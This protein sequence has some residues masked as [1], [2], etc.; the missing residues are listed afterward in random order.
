[1]SFVEPATISFNVSIKTKRKKKE[2]KIPLKRPLVRTN[3]EIKSVSC[4][5]I[6]KKRK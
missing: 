3:V 5:C 1:M 4:D 6:K 2:K